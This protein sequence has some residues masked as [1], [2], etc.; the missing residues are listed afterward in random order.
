LA[1]FCGQMGTILNSGL[2]LLSGLEVLH[3]QMKEK[4]L[5]I[6]INEMIEGV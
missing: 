3:S 1:S 2:N 4:K 6:I 5:K